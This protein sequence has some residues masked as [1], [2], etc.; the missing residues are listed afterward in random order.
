MF[1]HR[2]Y[3][4]YKL[5]CTARSCEEVEDYLASLMDQEFDTIVDDGSIT[6]VHA[7]IYEFSCKFMPG[8][9]RYRN[10]SLTCGMNGRLPV[11]CHQLMMYRQIHLCL[12]IARYYSRVW[13]YNSTTINITTDF[14][15]RIQVKTREKYQMGRRTM[16]W[17]WMMT[18]GH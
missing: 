9:F 15:T 18:D 4:D 11:N 12:P 3:I 2:S 13:I 14:R 1:C 10:D 16:S 17:Q 6:Q 7:C 5:V 8:C